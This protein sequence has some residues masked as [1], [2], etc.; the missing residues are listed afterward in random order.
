MENE[1]AKS[2]WQIF[3]ENFPWRDVILGFLIPKVIFLYG[4]NR[5]MPFV[6]G[7]YAIIWCLVVF[8][9]GYTK[10]RKVNIFAIL[11]LVLILIRILVVI[12]ERD[13][14]LYLILVALD[15]IIFGLIFLVSLFFKRTIMEVFADAVGSKAPEA[16]KCSRYY[17]KAWRIVTFVWGVTYLLYALILVL[18]NVKDLKTVGQIDMF[19]WIPILV[20]LFIF[21]IM[22]PRWYWEKYCKAING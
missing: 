3:I 18:M 6:W 1:K 21:T 17:S 19:A 15:E 11:A 2:T 22:F 10:T 9:I 13:P 14:R 4:L 12:A 20:A 8:F 16:V 5:K 7:G